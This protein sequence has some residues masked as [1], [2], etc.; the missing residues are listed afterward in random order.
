MKNSS[1]KMKV[2]SF[3]KALQYTCFFVGLVDLDKDYFSHRRWNECIFKV[4]QIE[5][6][7]NGSQLSRRP[8]I[9]IPI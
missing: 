4:T 2:A 1:T 5:W 8:W 7:I 3:L 9:V 6:S